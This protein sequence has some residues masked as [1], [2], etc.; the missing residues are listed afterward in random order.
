MSP[1]LRLA[2]L[3]CVALAVAPVAGAETVYVD[4]VLMTPT[5]SLAPTYYP[6]RT[7][8]VIPATY[9][10]PSVYATAYSTVYNLAPTAFMEATPTAYLTPTAWETGYVTQRYRRG[11]FGWLWP[12]YRERVYDYDVAPAMYALPTAATYVP[13]TMITTAPFVATSPMML[14]A[15]R[16]ET[17]ATLC[18]E[19]ARVSTGL[20]TTAPAP[21][22][23]PTTGPPVRNPERR[24]DPV[25]VSV[26][27][28]GGEPPL[29]DRPVPPIRQEQARPPVAQPVPPVADPAPAPRAADSPPPA[30]EPP[31][32]PDD[33]GDKPAAPRVVQKPVAP[34]TFGL[35]RG[36]VLSGRSN[37]PEPWVKIRIISRTDP[38]KFEARKVTTDVG[39]FFAVHVPPG[40]WSI[41]VATDSGKFEPIQNIVVLGGEITTESGRPM[42][43]L[44]INR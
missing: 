23:V 25:V 1:L 3:G 31:A 2:C 24:A 5:I 38:D 36:E 22:T 30:Q 35:L 40:D 27:R 12:R 16:I 43:L 8:A 14:S 11:L 42:P 41:Q 21:T 19:P 37:Q 44:S 15:P 4:S 33:L 32:L 9:A 18:G 34:P 29:N 13:S 26:P 20:P 39:G 7:S 6:T 10:A 17:T 28:D